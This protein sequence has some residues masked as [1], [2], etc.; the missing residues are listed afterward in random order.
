MEYFDRP[1][2]ATEE[3]LEHYLLFVF[4]I[5]LDVSK[6]DSDLYAHKNHFMP[7][8]LSVQNQNQ[9]SSQQPQLLDVQ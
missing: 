3:D 7:P 1:S 9:I 2:E 6:S 4:R 5:S 8:Q